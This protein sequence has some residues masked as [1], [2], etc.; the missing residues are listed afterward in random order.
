MAAAW[1]AYKPDAKWPLKAVTP[2]ADREGWTTAAVTST[3]HRPTS[4]ERYRP[5]C[6]ARM[7]L[8]RTIL[9]VAQDVGEKRAAQIA[10]IYGKFLPKGQ[11]RET[12]S[13]KKAHPSTPRASPNS[14][15]SSNL[16]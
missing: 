4:A 9:D 6:A 12:F 11:Q 16:Q 5:T 3:R 10:L 14:A 8:D 1:M 13:G 2:I 7:N 15:G